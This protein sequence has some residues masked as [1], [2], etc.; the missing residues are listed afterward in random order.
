MGIG[1][2]MTGLQRTEHAFREG[3]ANVKPQRELEA[4]ARQR[5]EGVSNFAI[6]IQ[7]A[8]EDERKRIARELHD[9]VCQR[10]TAIRMHMNV[11]ENDIPAERRTGLRRL[12]TIKQHI[13]EMIAEVR[14][15]SSNLRP[16]ALDL[17]GLR[18][19]LHMLC[20]ETEET[21][22]VRVEF[23]P[24]TGDSRHI[25]AQVEIALFRIAQE[26]IMNAARHASAKTIWV[27]L[28][29]SGGSAD[30]TVRD[31]GSGFALRDRR[32]SGG[33]GMGLFTMRERAELLG[34]ACAI[35]TG[36]RRGTV[37]HVSIP[38]QRGAAL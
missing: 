19:A 32:C 16:S 37:V 20:R 10:L 11:L 29:D 36:L 9:D 30:L 17:F 28:S 13:D 24:S 34:G 33:H 35:E 6:M 26:A 5:S 14:R 3:E 22:G 27:L 38:L 15:I 23:R 31:D 25:D 4:A 1:M 18:K 12:R 8:Q 21:H 7:R 2:E